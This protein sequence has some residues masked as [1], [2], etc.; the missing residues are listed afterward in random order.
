M[1]LNINKS[2]GTLL[3]TLADRQIDT[4]T[5]SLALF[6]TGAVRYGEQYNE[7][8]VK[9]LENFAADNAPSTPLRGQLWYD[10]NTDSLKSWNGSDWQTTG[11]NTLQGDV[12]GVSS[13]STIWTTLSNTGVVPGTYTKLA[14]NAQ[15]RI[16]YGSKFGFQDI[17]DA[18]GFVPCPCPT[19]NAN[20]NTTGNTTT[21]ANTNS[22]TIGGNFNA[23][24]DLAGDL[25]GTLT[26]QPGFN[27]FNAMI[28]DGVVGTENLAQNAV[29][30]RFITADTTFSTANTVLT[31]TGVA[32]SYIICFI[33]VEPQIPTTGSPPSSLS[34]TLYHNGSTITTNSTIRYMTS[35]TAFHLGDLRYVGHLTVPSTGGT[36][37][38]TVSKTVAAK[39]QIVAYQIYR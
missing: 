5:C 37:T 2:D 18:L 30:K 17:V 14:V 28:S 10:T 12:T 35:A 22:G 13:G 9:L 15:G 36:Q 8:L 6:G 32:N 27:Q 4:S 26:L 29:T 16:T 23:T 3:T 34:S 24:I 33:E 21:N 39:A 1:P 38:I 7:N 25:S 20:G 31:F 11:A 19:G